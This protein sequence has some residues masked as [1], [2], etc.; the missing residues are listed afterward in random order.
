MTHGRNY[1]HRWALACEPAATWRFYANQVKLL[2]RVAAKLHDGQVPSPEDWS[3]VYESFGVRKE[4]VRTG[5]EDWGG[6]PVGINCEPP[7][8]GVGERHAPWWI[9]DLQFDRVVLSDI[10]NQS[11]ISLAHIRPALVWGSGQPARLAFATGARSLSLFGALTLQLV[12]AV[13]RARVRGLFWLW[14]TVP[15]RAQSRANQRRW[16]K[17]KWNVAE[18]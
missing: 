7:P 10:L 17:K 2:L 16:C 9:Q 12:F 3:G 5:A 8:R 13:A 15:S 11:W 14:G 18:H 1:S 6:E 4:V